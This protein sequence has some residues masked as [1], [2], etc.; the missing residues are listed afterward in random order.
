MKKFTSLGPLVVDFVVALEKMP[1][2]GKMNY[3]SGDEHGEI[4]KNLG[5]HAAIVAMDLA[6]LGWDSDK[7][8]V[9]GAVGNDANGSFLESKIGEKDITSMLY[10]SESPTAENIIIAIRGEEK[11]YDLY[12]GSN[13]DLKFDYV[14]DVLENLKPEILYCCPGYTGIDSDL[15]EI[16]SKIKERWESFIFLDI[17]DPYNKPKDFVIP[18]LEYV[19]VFKLNEDEAELL[20]GKSNLHS[21][22]EELIELGVNNVVI[23][24]GPVGVKGVIDDK[25]FSQPPFEVDSLDQTGC[26]DAFSAGL[27]YKML[28]H[29]QLLS[30]MDSESL[31]DALAFGQ[32]TGAIAATQAGSTSAVSKEMVS[33]L[34]ASDKRKVLRETEIKDCS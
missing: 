3:V 22:L 10:K 29:D 23:T 31:L 6:K 16:F 34:L 18:A 20:T 7:I 17:V 27:I 13:L 24:Q 15:E 5:G 2:P 11:R 1:T 9:V 12:P 21:S 8:S 32:A 14:M 28:E 4:K 30:S 26:G 33:N 19:D 25:I